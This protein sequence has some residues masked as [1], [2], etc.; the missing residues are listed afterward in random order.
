MSS[1]VIFATSSILSTT[2]C[3][4]GTYSMSGTRSIGNSPGSVLAVADEA[5]GGGVAVVDAAADAE[6]AGGAE[7]AGVTLEDVGL[8]S[9]G[10]ASRWQPRAARPA[11]RENTRKRGWAS[12]LSFM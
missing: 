3:G 1:F 8:P 6:G 2:F 4:D 7:A 12:G 9:V 10:R 5:V 11:T